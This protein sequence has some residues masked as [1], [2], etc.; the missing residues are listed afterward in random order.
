MYVTVLVIIYT[1][2][3]R[4]CVVNDGINHQKV[5]ANV[6]DN[7]INIVLWH[8]TKYIIHHIYIILYVALRFSKPHEG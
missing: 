6:K 7:L 3:F 4:F 5:S 8:T 2:S 1:D